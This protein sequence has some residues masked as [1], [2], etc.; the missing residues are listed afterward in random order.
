MG[1]MGG[2]Q[3]QCGAEQGGEVGKAKWW[4]MLCRCQVQPQ[5]RHGSGVLWDP[6]GQP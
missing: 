2:E 1:N 4:R 5:G 3:E 6:G